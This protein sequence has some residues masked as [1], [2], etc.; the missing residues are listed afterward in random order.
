MGRELF[1]DGLLTSFILLFRSTE[2]LVSLFFS[3]LLERIIK[4]SEIVGELLDK[5]RLA[6]HPQP[7]LLV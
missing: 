3:Y 7:V 1:I 5:S 4:G 2:E 6:D